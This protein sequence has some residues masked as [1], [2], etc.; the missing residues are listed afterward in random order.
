VADILIC[1]TRTKEGD[2]PTKGITLFLVD[3]TTEGVSVQPLPTM[4]GTRKLSAIEFKNV[5]LGTESILG[6]LH[7][8]WSPLQRVLQRA[9]VGLSAECV[10]GAQRAM[11]IATEYAKVR[12]QYDRCVSGHQTSLR[13]DV[14]GH[15]KRS[16]DAVLGR[17][18]PGSRG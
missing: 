18:G 12:I 9:Q 2:D 7:H 3:P 14:C 17:L 16:L 10:G 4:D 13:P 11:E 5:R 1:V 6:D 15:G 8:G